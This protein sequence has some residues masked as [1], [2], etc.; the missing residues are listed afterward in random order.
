[1]QIADPLCGAT[2]FTRDYGG[3]RREEKRRNDIQKLIVVKRIHR[4]ILEPENDRAD[5]TGLTGAWRI[6]LFLDQRS[7]NGRDGPWTR[8]TNRTYL[9]RLAKVRQDLAAD[10]PLAS[11]VF[12]HDNSD[13]FRF[14]ILE[15]GIVQRRVTIVKLPVQFKKNLLFLPLI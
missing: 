2:V 8:Q 10:L 7:H 4:C 12:H 11:F 1:M 3:S 9:F 13:Q 6:E 15:H 14:G 5:F